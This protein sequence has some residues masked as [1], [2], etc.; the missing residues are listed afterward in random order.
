M[1]CAEDHHGYSVMLWRVILRIPPGHPRGAIQGTSVM[2][3]E[4]LPLDRARSLLLLGPE[5]GVFLMGDG[6]GMMIRMQFA[7]SFSFTLG[8]FL[9]GDGGGMMMRMQFAS[10]TL[11]ARGAGGSRCGRHS[12]ELL[13]E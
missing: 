3:V 8:V 6:G 7:P 5:V 2:P 9:M 11:K 1:V 4:N 10:S 12:N 13:N